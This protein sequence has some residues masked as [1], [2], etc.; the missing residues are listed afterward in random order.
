MPRPEKTHKMV[1]EVFFYF[2][3]HVFSPILQTG[4]DPSKGVQ[5]LDGELICVIILCF[6]FISVETHR[7]GEQGR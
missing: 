3:S 2:I 4:C 5:V 7:A 6:I 1:V